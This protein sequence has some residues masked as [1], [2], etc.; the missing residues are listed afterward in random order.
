MTL[1]RDQFIRINEFT[2]PGIKRTMT[3][4]LVWHYT[5]NP[6]ASAANHFTYFN[7][8]RDRYASAHIF[9]D[10]KEAVC[11]IPL[12]ELAY[13]ANQANPY[14]IG[15]ELCIERDGTFHVNTIKQA[16]AI[17]K[18]LN[19]R[20][21]LTISDQLRHYD[22]N[23][24]I[25]P[26]PWVDNPS[27]WQ[28][29]KQQLFA[30]DTKEDET[31]KLE[32]W[33]W[34]DL[35]DALSNMYHLS[36]NGQVK[37]PLITDYTWAEKAYTGR[38]KR[39]EFA[40]LNMIVLKGTYEEDYKIRRENKMEKTKV[41]KKR[42]RNYGFWTALVSQ[43]LLVVQIGAK[44]LFDYTLT[45]DFAAEIVLFVDAILVVLATLGIISNPTKPDG[46]YFN[47]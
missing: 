45:E 43:L 2:R 9:I 23:G 16:L 42:L 47:L 25:C 39:D 26:K 46:K 13:H 36:V 44:L 38:L 31:L 6:G 34:K 18:E 24:K 41:E 35:G 1:W 17:G 33:Q 32:Q 28:D 11:I 22:V 12:D 20:Y 3:R 8:L 40:W 21:G 15:V 5:A 29:F 30:P 7:N 27:S 4:N 14:S 10:S 19:R 37:P